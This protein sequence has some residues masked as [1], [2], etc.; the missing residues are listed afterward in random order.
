MNME[1]RYNGTN[2]KD[3]KSRKLIE[4]ATYLIIFLL[5]A[6]AVWSNI[7]EIIHMLALESLGH[8]YIYNWSLFRP[9]VHCTNCEAVTSLQVF[10]YSF[11]PYVVDLLAMIIGALF[12]KN[13]IMRYIQ[14]FGYF[15]ITM[16]CCPCLSLAMLL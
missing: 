9:F 15:D 12:Y 2:D 5:M 6:L 7:H 10:Y 8:S 13:R 3:K 14:H 16:R 11:A 1:I 4:K